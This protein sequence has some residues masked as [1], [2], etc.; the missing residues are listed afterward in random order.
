[1]FTYL[2][3]IF[4]KKERKRLLFL[5][6]GM[7]GLGITESLGI[8]FLVPITYLFLEPESFL[9]HPY[10]QTFLQML[11]A[12]AIPS[13][14]SYFLLIFGIIILFFLLLKMA[15][16][17]TIVYWRNKTVTYFENRLSTQLLSA[18]LHQPYLLYTKT[19]SSILFKNITYEVLAVSQHFMDVFLVLFSEGIIIVCILIFL[20]ILYPIITLMGCGTIGLLMGLTY[21]WMQPEL[22]RLSTQHTQYAEDYFRIGL[23]TLE[24]MQE[25][26]IFQSQNFFL[27]RYHFA[28]SKA[29]E[30]KI[31]FMVGKAFPRYFIETVLFSTFIG[32]ILVYSFLGIPF[33]NLIGTMT[34]LGVAVVKI[35]PSLVK[36]GQSLTSIRFYIKNVKILANIIQNT[37]K[38]KIIALDHSEITEQFVRIR[39]ENIYFSYQSKQQILQNLSLEIQPFQITAFVGESGSGKSTL[40]GILT[41]LFSA[42]KG[43][44]YFGDQRITSEYQMS[45]QSKIG[46]VP[47]QIFLLNESILE[48]ITFGI[49]KEKINQNQVWK[50]LEMAQLTEFVQNLPQGI[51]T[52]IGEKGI[53]LSG[54][55]RQ[56]LGIARALYRQPEIL[57]LDEATSALDSATEQKINQAIRQLRQKMTVILI[58]HRPQTIRQADWIFWLENGKIK[59]KGTWM[60]LIKNNPSFKKL[61][62][63][64]INPSGF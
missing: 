18:Y 33:E 3:I 27:E 35:F 16:S 31:K 60:R 43:K 62:Y 4:M 46:Y 25:V 7:L 58:A 23:E 1:M 50:V 28:F 37:E 42:Q 48:N 8:S 64:A 36:V 59:D 49:Y 12:W 21:Q 22:R 53:Q 14:P 57:I 5:L 44:L 51:N 29:V 13:N 15:Y 45:Y 61:L 54:G 38:Q 17:L 41:G 47:Q 39:L 11:P 32:V 26:Q 19:D 56:R 6:L 40:I 20:L 30:T 2:Q 9:N 10:F 24:G 34:I 52:L 55:Q 63:G